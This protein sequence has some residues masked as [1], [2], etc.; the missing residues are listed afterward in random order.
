[1]IAK[2]SDGYEVEIDENRLDDWRY[3]T[4]LR[5]ID[6]GETELIVDAAEFILGGEKE[7]ERLASHLEKDGHV[8][9]TVMVEALQE[10]M[11]SVS[12]L[13]NS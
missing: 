8:S 5:K 12:E 4:I 1:M 11:T 2:L 3:L 9:A 13:K 10:L 7:V 6:K